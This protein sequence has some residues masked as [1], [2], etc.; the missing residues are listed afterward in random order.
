MSLAW[1]KIIPKCGKVP[2][3]E[4]CSLQ[5][6]DGR[7]YLYG[8]EVGGGNSLIFNEYDLVKDIWSEVQFKNALPP[9]MK[10]QTCVKFMDSLFIAD[11]AQNSCKIHQILMAPNDVGVS[12]K[13]KRKAVCERP[14]FEEFFLKKDFCDVIFKVEGKEF[15]CHKIILSKASQYFFNMF[16]SEMKESKDKEITVDDVKASTFEE[17]LRYVYCGEL[18]LK[19]E[20]A[21]DLYELTDKWLL[22][23]LRLS[24]REFLEQN[25]SISNFG[26]IAQRADDLGAEELCDAVADFAMNNYEL[27]EEKNLERTPHSILRKIICKSKLFMIKRKITKKSQD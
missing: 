8:K 20:F 6:Y 3:I 4:S 5:V 10:K 27:L 15:Y 19:E 16:T 11:W 12:Q 2:R 7:L 26:Q 17:L 14:G 25:L 13:K 9:Q 24:C 22:K 23:D 1:T 21:M 18:E